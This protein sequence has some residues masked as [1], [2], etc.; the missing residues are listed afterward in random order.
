VQRPGRR[1]PDAGQT[2]AE[3]A[4]IVGGIALVCLI[5][6]LLLGH[7]IDGQFRKP[8]ASLP[9]HQPFTPP[10]TPGPGNE[11][12]TLEDCA[13]GGWQTYGFGSRQ[14]CEDYVTSGGGSGP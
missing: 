12:S 3:Y 10:V 6:A 2:T 8:A 7:E 11:P 13:H 5:A 14:A 1:A 9:S 4:L